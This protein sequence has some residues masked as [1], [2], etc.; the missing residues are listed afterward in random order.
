MPD[1]SGTST[2][3]CDLGLFRFVEVTELVEELVVCPPE[4]E[5]EQTIPGGGRDLYASLLIGHV[6]S[7]PHHLLDIKELP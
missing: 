5:F 3:I 4:L 7:S 1:I 6:A 2:F